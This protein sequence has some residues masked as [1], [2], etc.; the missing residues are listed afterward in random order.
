[1]PFARHH[2]SKNTSLFSRLWGSSAAKWNYHVV[3]IDSMNLGHEP[4]P[5]GLWSSQTQ[6]RNSA[7]SPF[8][9]ITRYQLSVVACRCMLPAWG[10]RP[11]KDGCVC[12]FF[13]CLS[14]AKLIVSWQ[15]AQSPG[16]EREVNIAAWPEYL[17]SKQRF[18]FL[19]R[20]SLWRKVYTR[21]HTV[22]LLVFCWKIR[23]KMVGCNSGH[24]SKSERVLPQQPWPY[25]LTASL[26]MKCVD[27][28][29]V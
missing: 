21:A 16:E 29:A 13:P 10:G 7:L 14:G 20:L 23:W 12:S 8:Y 28:L 11:L 25:V 17:S 3:F 6:T 27:I 19:R 2:Y 26:Y 9:R 24:I 4:V 18:S 15:S 1:M 5:A 22:C